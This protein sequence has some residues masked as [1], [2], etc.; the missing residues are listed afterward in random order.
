MPRAS[1]PES[2]QSVTP[3]PHPWRTSP[4]HPSLPSLPSGPLSLR[5]TTSPTLQRS[6]RDPQVQGLS[7]PQPS[8][9]SHRPCPASSRCWAAQAAVRGRHLPPACPVGAAPRQPW[10]GGPGSAEAWDGRALELHHLR[11]RDSGAAQAPARQQ[12]RGAAKG[13]CQAAEAPTAR[14]LRSHRPPSGTATGSGT[15]LGRHHWARRGGGTRTDPAGA[16][17][18]ERTTAR[19]CRGGRSPR[20]ERRGPA[21]PRRAAAGSYQPGPRG[22]SG[23]ARAR[24]APAA[25]GLASGGQS[26]ACLSPSSDPGPRRELR[27]RTPHPPAPSRRA[28]SAAP[29]VPA[30][31]PARARPGGSGRAQWRPRPPAVKGPW[32]TIGSDRDS[33]AE[34]EEIRILMKITSLWYK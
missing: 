19:A 3:V 10:S 20:Q 16:R 14:P 7:T 8:Q 1:K 26:P 5:T 28:A 15:R 17:E 27:P 11:E 31:R 13:R 22:R 9:R 21:R 24:Q 4:T 34:V 6:L 18:G 30:G 32:R 33:E 2:S 25:W 12:P 29:P 23:G